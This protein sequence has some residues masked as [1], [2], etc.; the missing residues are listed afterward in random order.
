MKLLAQLRRPLTQAGAA[1]ARLV[2]LLAGAAA[3]AQNGALPPAAPPDAAASAVPDAHLDYTPGKAPKFWSVAAAETIMA[4][5]PDYS[6]AYFNA[7]TYVNGYELYGFDMLY[8]ATGDQKYF[9]Y[10]K[11]Y[12][13]QFMDENGDFRGVV[14]ARGQTQTSRLQQPR[15]HDDRQ[16][17]R[18]ALRVHQGRAL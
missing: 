3:L 18:H 7:W 15:Q 8:R 16:H 11:R 6:K 14:N 12:I 9:D 4:R 10:S 5:W 17:R 2:F 13:D 1:L